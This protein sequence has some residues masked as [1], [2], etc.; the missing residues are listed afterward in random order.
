M[1]EGTVPKR[2]VRQWRPDWRLWL[3]AGIFFPLLVGLGSWQISRAHDK[4]KLLTQWEQQLDSL[5][6]ATAVSR[7][8]TPGQP[9]QLEGRYRAGHDWLLD[10]RTR[11]GQNGYEVLTV[12]D[13]VAG[14]PVLINR[15]W[16]AAPRLRRDLPE[17]TT[18]SESVVVTARAAAYP[19][20]PVLA[21]TPDEAGW[22]RRVQSLKPNVVQREV[23]G[24]TDILLK[25][26]GDDQP[27]AY[28]ADWTPDFMGPATHYGYAVQW[29]SLAAVLTVLTL[30]ASFRKPEQQKMDQQDDQHNG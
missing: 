2:V 14:P 20:P 12:F 11:N 30:I 5:P 9:V 7:G 16:V 13:P 19:T 24:A 3:F 25:L 1:S 26:E 27:G 10:N 21:E 17:I 23:P 29:F 8:I 4:E 15:G 22:P 6:W 28:S 18:P